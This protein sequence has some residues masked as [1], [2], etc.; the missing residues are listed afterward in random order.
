[1]KYV[2]WYPDSGR[3]KDRTRETIKLFNETKRREHDN[4]LQFGVFKNGKLPRSDG[5]GLF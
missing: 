5:S 2:Y 3:V 1:M 4:I